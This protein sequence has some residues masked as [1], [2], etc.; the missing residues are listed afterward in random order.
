MGFT[1]PDKGEG[2]SNIQ[3][4]LFQEDIDILVDGLTGDDFVLSGGVVSVTG[5]PTE[6]SV[7]VAKAILEQGKQQMDQFGA[8]VGELKRPKK[9]KRD[10][11]G[12]LIGVE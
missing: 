11:T 4:I 1:V 6:M 3:S 7:S 2:A 10:N 8:L 12:R 5:S 9:A